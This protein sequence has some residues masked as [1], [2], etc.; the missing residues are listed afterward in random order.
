MKI[1]CHGVT[2][3]GDGG[4]AIAAIFMIELRGSVIAAVIDVQIV[5]I[6][7]YVTREQHPIARGGGQHERAVAVVAVVAGGAAVVIDL[8]RLYARGDGE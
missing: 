8:E 7:I 6:N 2:R 1:D 4:A 3:A 5:I